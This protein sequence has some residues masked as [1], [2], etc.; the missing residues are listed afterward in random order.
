[1]VVV[2]IFV[3]GRCS[4]R[5]GGGGWSASNKVQRSQPDYSNEMNVFA[6]YGGASDSQDS[7]KGDTLEGWVK[8]FH[9][10]A[11]STVVITND[12]VLKL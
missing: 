11:P 10:D 6:E 12:N 8:P 9:R 3:E 7:T 4:F 5:A 2:N 1:M